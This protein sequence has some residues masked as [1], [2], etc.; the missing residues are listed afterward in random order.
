MSIGVFLYFG[1]KILIFKSITLVSPR[2]IISVFGNCRSMHFFQPT[3]G[4]GIKYELSSDFIVSYWTIG[5]G[6][7]L[8]DSNFSSLMGME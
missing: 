1:Q 5:G 8:V 2:F 4:I 7:G 3:L 6:V